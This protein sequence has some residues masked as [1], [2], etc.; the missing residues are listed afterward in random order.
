[1]CLLQIRFPEPGHFLKSEPIWIAMRSHSR[2]CE[3]NIISSSIFWSLKLHDFVH[4]LK[5]EPT[6]FWTLN[7]PRWH[8]LK[9]EP[10]CFCTSSTKYKNWDVSF[11]KKGG[12]YW[13]EKDIAQCVIYKNIVE[14]ARISTH[15]GCPG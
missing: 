9:S 7:L 13:Q 15:N 1:L 8:I 14:F 11:V 4:L 12:A 6:C 2:H 3:V 5:S 10:T